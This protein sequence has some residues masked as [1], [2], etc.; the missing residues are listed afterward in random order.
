MKDDIREAISALADG[1]VEGDAG[2]LIDRLQSDAELQRLW[3]RYHLLSEAIGDRLA[4]PAGTELADRVHRAVEAEPVA[5]PR[6]RPRQ[7]RLLRPVAGLALAASVAGAA[8]FGLHLLAGPQAS[9]ANLA[10]R[11]LSATEVA[12]A[13]AVSAAGARLSGYLV[14]YS[15][16]AGYGTRG[17]LPYA[18]VVDYDFSR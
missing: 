16:Y 2:R 6:A 15:E 12:D 10:G 5:L 3:A 4:V 17:M 18:R 13:G 8:I 1:E 7:A 11:S 14:N 9:Q